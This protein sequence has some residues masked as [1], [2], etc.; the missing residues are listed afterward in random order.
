MN[1]VIKKAVQQDIP[2]IHQIT[3]KAFKKYAD[4]LGFPEKVS[5]L[6]ETYN[7]IL[8][9]MEKKTILIAYADKKPQGTIRYHIDRG[10][11]CAYISRFGVNPECHNLGIGKA[12]ML[13]VEKE[14]K[15]QKIDYIALHTASKVTNLIR[16]YYGIGYYV[17]STDNDK[18]YIRV[19]LRKDLREQTQYCSKSQAVL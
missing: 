7:S 4:D 14:L 19:L 8:E 1:I 6:D 13:E 17:H 16:F 9:D 11:N 15:Q 12:L 5:A 18:G 10:N 2:V 3:Q